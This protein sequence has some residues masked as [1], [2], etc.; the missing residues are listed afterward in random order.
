VKYDEVFDYV[1][2][3]G[4]A[5]IP[6]SGSGAVLG[7]DLDAFHTYRF[8]SIN[9]A[10]YWISVDGVVFTGGFQA[11]GNGYHYLQMI[12]R[13]ACL[14]EHFPDMVNEWDFV[15]YGTISYGE[16]IAST[17]PSY[18]FLD[19]RHHAG[20]DRFTVT[21]ED[22]NYVYIDEITV[23]TTGDIAPVVT[24]TR[25]LDNGSPET[26][27][28]VLDSPLPMGETTRFT[29]NDRVAVNVVE[30]VFAPADT[31]GD[32]DADLFDA[33]VF[34]NCFGRE[35]TSGPCQACDLDHSGAV[36]LFDVSSFTDELAGP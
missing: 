33:A 25:R 12:G 2:M 14:S 34:Q 16:Q 3:H 35:A 13:G 4:D 19:A 5:A 6:A 18:G 23:E 31:D 9:G 29:F 7:L 15:R 28:V 27:E 8:E 22:P 1:F 30:Y 32:G 11:Q 26:V 36:D 24:Q 17:C 21:F 10:R 20:L